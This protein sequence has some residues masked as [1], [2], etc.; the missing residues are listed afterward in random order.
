MLFGI[1]KEELTEGGENVVVNSFI[2]YT[3]HYIE[4]VELREIWRYEKSKHIFGLKTS[5]GRT[6]WET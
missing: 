6:N 5:K 4:K 3:L 1:R 2:I